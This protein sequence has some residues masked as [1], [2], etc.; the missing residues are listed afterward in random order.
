MRKFNITVNGKTY[1]V[2]VEEIDAAYTAPTAPVPPPQPAAAAAPAPKPPAAPVA[3]AAPAASRFGARRRRQ[4]D[5]SDAGTIL[6]INVTVGQ[7]VKRGDVLAILEAMKMENVDHGAQRWKDRR[8]SRVPGSERELR[9]CAGRHRIAA[10]R[11][12]EER[13]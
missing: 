13:E 9:R 2:E 8:D 11:R 7:S 1:E 6:K 5:V 12:V 4:S 10:D 3:P